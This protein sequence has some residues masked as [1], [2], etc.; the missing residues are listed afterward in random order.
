MVRFT[1]IFAV[2][3][4]LVLGTMTGVFSAPGELEG[5]V[6]N[7]LQEPLSGCIV[8]LVN[9]GKSDTT[10]NGAFRITGLPLSIMNGAVYKNN[11]VLKGDRLF[12]GL[13]GNERIRLELFDMAGKLRGSTEKEL[14]A[15]A[16]RMDPLAFLNP[17]SPGAVYMAQIQFGSFKAAYTIAFSG[18]RQYSKNIEPAGRK[19]VLARKSADALDTLL[20]DCKGYTPEEIGIDNYTLDMGNIP[21]VKPNLIMILVDDMGYSDIGPFGGEISTP[22]LDSLAEKGLR[23]TQ[24]YNTSKCF[25]SRATLLTG[26]YAQQVNMHSSYPG[27]RNGVTLAEVMKT[28]GYRTLASGKHHS[29]VSL[30]DRGFD[31]YYGLRDGACNF[32]NPGNQRPGEPAPAQKRPGQRWWCIDEQCFQGYTPEEDDY[33]TT[34]YFTNYAL[35]YLEEYK[36]E[37]MPFF[38][39]LAYNAPHDPMQAWPDDI[40]RYRGKYMEGFEVIRNRRYQKQM[41]MGLFGDNAPLSV[42]ES[43]DWDGLSQ[44]DKDEWDLRMAVYAAMVDRMDWNVGRVLRKL[45][46]LGEM[47]NTLILFASDNGGSAEN[48]QIG[49]GEIG[50][51]TRWASVKGNWANV[52]NTPFRKYKNYSHEGGIC[53]PLIAFWPKVIKN[54]GAIIREPGHFIDVMATYVDI[55]DAA[56]PETFKGEDIVPM[57]GASMYPFFRGRQRPERGPIFWQWGNGK[58]VRDGK[59]KAVVKGS[60]WELYDMDVDRT[61]TNNLASEQSQRLDDMIQMWNDWYAST[62]N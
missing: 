33:Y 38:L 57:Q 30:Y 45:E 44:G 4:I 52:S 60:G 13:S 32:F 40:A 21:V 26:A 58:A 5:T 55:T 36:D 25:P 46:E 61:E 24:F 49:D 15:G 29:N 2:A 51:M 53:T 18:Y 10:E 16:Y 28:A 50:T 12:F 34:D 8:S 20:I 6:I 47:E 11:S 59:W 54:H 3:I 42:R 39:Y 43:P 27:I 56:Y 23:F 35:D 7:H 9:E 22:N 14:K 19:I 62:G 41:D 1:K 48:V 17:A 31:R 37:N